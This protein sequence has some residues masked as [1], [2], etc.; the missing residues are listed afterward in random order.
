M[1]FPN[2]TV[3]KRRDKHD[4]NHFKIE[5]VKLILSNFLNNKSRIAVSNTLLKLIFI[6][7]T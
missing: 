7:L 1:H 5:L 3:G 2:L 6:M 4:L